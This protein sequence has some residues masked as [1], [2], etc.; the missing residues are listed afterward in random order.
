MGRKIDWWLRISNW[1]YVD[2]EQIGSGLTLIN[3][4]QKTECTLQVR[5]Q[6]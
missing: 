5:I 2:R 6:F 1:G 3:G 4:D